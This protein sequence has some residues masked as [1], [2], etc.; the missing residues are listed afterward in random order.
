MPLDAYIAYIIAEYQREAE[1]LH[2]ENY[3]SLMLL[4]AARPHVK[5]PEKLKAYASPLVKQKPRQNTEERL[6]GFISTLKAGRNM[7]NEAV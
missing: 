7:T 3:N 4:Y 1:A 5:R 6:K 2:R